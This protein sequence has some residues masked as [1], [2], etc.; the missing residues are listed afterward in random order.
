M[1]KDQQSKENSSE[2][3]PELRLSELERYAQRWAK[4]YQG[5]RRVCLYNYVPHHFAVYKELFSQWVVRYGLVF[6]LCPDIDPGALEELERVTEQRETIHCGYPALFDNRFFAVYIDKPDDDYVKHWIM[7]V[8]KAVEEMPSGVVTDEMFWVLYDSEPRVDERGQDGSTALTTSVVQTALSGDLFPALSSIELVKRAREWAEEWPDIQEVRLCA[9]KGPVN[10]YALVFETADKA[11]LESSGFWPDS[12]IPLQEDLLSIYKDPG[13]FTLTHWNMYLVGIDEEPPPEFVH[14]DICWYLLGERTVLLDGQTKSSNSGVGEGTNWITGEHLTRLWHIRDFELFDYLK[15]GL[16]AYT[17]HGKRIVDRDSRERQPKYSSIDEAILEIKTE[18]RRTESIENGKPV[19]SDKGH[20]YSPHRKLNEREIEAKAKELMHQTVLVPLD[21]AIATNLTLPLD[22]EQAQKMIDEA[23]EY[24]FKMA[25]VEAFE[26]ADRLNV[27]MAAADTSTAN[28]RGQ[29]YFVLKGEY[30]DVGFQ[31]EEGHIKD[32]GSI[33]YIVQLLSRPFTMVHV[34]DLYSMV[35]PP[36]ATAQENAR[37][38]ADMSAEQLEEEGME[39]KSG[40]H[41]GGKLQVDEKLL[42]KYREAERE[43]QEAKN[44][45]EGPEKAL[46]LKEAQM[47]FDDLSRRWKQQ[48]PGQVLEVSGPRINAHN[49]IKA[50]EKIFREAG[51]PQL[52]YHIQKY[53]KTGTN[54]VYSPEPDKAPSWF[55]SGL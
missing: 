21:N 37:K 53:V 48:K 51:L 24:L 49:Q 39:R 6:E 38:C 4:R 12:L 50:A 43:L 33:R 17:R 16:Q 31:G 32:R 40:L 52:A 19:P 14:S 7:H 27:Q 45:P 42:G 36:T 2:H 8:R 22:A 41:S 26:A 54:C 35:K 9:G 46:L 3:F 11:A 29:D 13:R 10:R 55:V 28:D 23:K 34:S 1:E 18:E 25:D 30:W 5:I 20:S 47:K 15:K 44:E